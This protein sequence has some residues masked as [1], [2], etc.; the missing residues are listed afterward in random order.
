MVSVPEA[1]RLIHE[2]I[3]RP[4][5]ERIK[6]EQAE[7]R[8]LAEQVKA[9]RDFPPFDRVAMDGIAVAYSAIEE[10]WEGFRVEGLQPAGQPRLTLKNDKN[11]IEVMTGAML[12]IGCDTVIRY[13]DVILVNDIAKVKVKGIERGQSIHTRATDARRGDTIL[14][15]GQRISTSEV[16]LLASVGRLETD[17]FRFPK[18]AIVSTGTELVDIHD[19]PQPHQIRRSNS[20]ALQAALQSMACS[21]DLF[22][23]ADERNAMERELGKILPLYDVIILTGGVSKGKFDFVPAVL[24]SLGVTTVFHQV[25]QKPGKPLFFG[26]TKKQA[27]F[28]LPGNP[29]S[30]FMCFYRYIRPWLLTGMGIQSVPSSAILA[31]DITLKGGDLTHFLQVHVAFEGG[32]QLAYPR[33]GGGSGDFANLRQADGFLEL[34]MGQ[35]EYKSGQAYPYIPFRGAY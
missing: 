30:T 7:G 20:Y 23:L 35:T 1:T 9:D 6:I 18:V 2:V 4:G 26:T 27:V 8:V 5:M 12:P 15:V 31:E 13:E 24:D 10:G 29:V 28:G 17:V 25:S 14:D 19:R 21:A 16:A 22:H 34:P 32:R 3:Y 11:C 33:P